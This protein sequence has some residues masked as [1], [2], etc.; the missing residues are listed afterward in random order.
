MLIYIIN[1]FVVV[2]AA[3]LAKK[4]KSIFVS[5]LLLGIAFASMIL[6]AGLRNRIVGTDTGYYVRDFNGIRTFADAFDSGN[7]GGEYG[8]WILQWFVHLVSNEYLFF[9]LAI[10]L[11]VVGCYQRIII[12]F[13]AN[14][15]ISFF[16]FIA[17]YYTFFFNAARQGIACAIFALAIGPLLDGNFKKYVGYV[18][19]AFLF[20]SSAIVML[21]TFFIVNR[22]STFK[23]SLII[24]LVGCVMF[25]FADKIIEFAATYQPRYAIYGEKSMGGG[26]L[27]VGFSLANF[28]F[29]YAFKK[30]VSIERTRYDCF[31]NMLLLDILIGLG[32]TFMG[33]DPSGLLR[34]SYYLGFVNMLI[35][36]IVFKNLTTPL[37]KFVI[38]YFFVLVHF[39]YFI[40]ATDRFSNLVPYEFNP[41]I[42]LR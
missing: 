1:L 39:T 33:T 24:V 16:I 30:S 36:A 3:F 41:F 29:L 23:N 14:I 22:T 28:I 4:S 15:V 12:T 17:M 26:Y 9:L 18:L 25:F 19:L 37:S 8:F 40:L 11:I 13:S 27:S 31:L 21:P 10:A 5:R 7:N 35:W 20:H 34:I 32:A 2:L 42:I 38:G 6:V